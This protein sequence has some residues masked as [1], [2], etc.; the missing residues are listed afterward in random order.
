MQEGW[1]HNRD[2]A[3]SLNYR[4]AIITGI[5]FN[6]SAANERRLHYYFQP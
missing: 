4:R 6:A 3:E 1:L 2:A 5:N